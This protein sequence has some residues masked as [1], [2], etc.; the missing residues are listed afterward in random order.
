MT[1]IPSPAP[2]K[3]GYETPA[4]G[5]PPFVVVAVGVSVRAPVGVAVSLV[6]GEGLPVTRV[7]GVGLPVT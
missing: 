3:V 4:S 7:V 5:S 2:I 1:S 6:V